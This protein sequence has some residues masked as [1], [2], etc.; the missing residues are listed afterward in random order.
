MPLGASACLSHL[1]ALPRPVCSAPPPPVPA[2]T[3]LP[4]HASLYLFKPSLCREDRQVLRRLPA[5]SP[6]TPTC[7]IRLSPPPSFT[8]QKLA[9]CPPPLPTRFSPAPKPLPVRL[10]QRVWS[11]E[12]VSLSGSVA[13]SVAEER[14]L[15]LV[16]GGGG[17]GGGA[18]KGSNT[19][20]RFC[21]CPEGMHREVE[22]LQ[23]ATRAASRPVG[24]FRR[25]RVRAVAGAGPCC[26]ACARCKRTTVLVSSP[27]SR[28]R[29]LPGRRQQLQGPEGP[30]A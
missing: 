27:C 17:G 1:R 21:S 5:H 4:P 29:R 19:L 8:T 18:R 16:G 3:P 7:T 22:E 6:R 10:R 14:R 15:L 30:P 20:P 25:M 11:N 24:H 28:R 12:R 13:E 2:P 26:R 9:A 23:A